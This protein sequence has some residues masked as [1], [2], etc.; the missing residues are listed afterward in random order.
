MNVTTPA[1]RIKTGL[2]LVISSVLMGAVDML[3]TYEVN[4]TIVVAFVT[5]GGTMMSAGILKKP[6]Q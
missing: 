3:S 1:F 4:A 6:Q 5:L 2:F